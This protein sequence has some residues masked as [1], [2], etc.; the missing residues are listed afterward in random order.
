MQFS[1]ELLY[2][3]DCFKKTMKNVE[4]YSNNSLPEGQSWKDVALPM[5]DVAINAPTLWNEQ[6]FGPFEPLE[7]V[8]DDDPD[9]MSDE[10]FEA[11]MERIWQEVKSSREPPPKK[12]RKAKSSTKKEDLG[13]GS[14]DDGVSTKRKKVTPG[15]EFFNAFRNFLRTHM[16][17][18]Q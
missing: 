16:K 11:Q 14:G 13:F 9:Y 1:E 7:I 6:E 15:E 3:M 17:K 2:M 4:A 18:E 5:V 10:Q 12:P 8:P